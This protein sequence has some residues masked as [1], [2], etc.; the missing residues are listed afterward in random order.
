[1]LVKDLKAILADLPDDAKIVLSNPQWKRSEI[2]GHQFVQH[3]LADDCPVLYLDAK[4][5]KG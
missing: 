1:M 3:S 4:N 5:F 2:I